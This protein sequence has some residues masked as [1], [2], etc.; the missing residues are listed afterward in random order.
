MTCKRV[1]WQIA[2]W[3][4]GRLDGREAQAVADHCRGCARC[5]SLADDERALRA[6]FAQAP[7]PSRQVDLWPAVAVRS[8]GL[9]RR[10]LC[11]WP[12]RLAY[13]S[14]L[15]GACCLLLLMTAQPTH[16]PRPGAVQPVAAVDE[17][18]ALS[19]VADTRLL[20]NVDTDSMMIEARYASTTG[21]S[22]GGED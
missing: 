8:S 22:S 3:I 5:A 6:R 10:G 9:T 17:A 15:A 1:E 13:G 2:D 20:P 19:L 11:L 21:S 12:R 7:V 16:V 14:A 18:H 4:A